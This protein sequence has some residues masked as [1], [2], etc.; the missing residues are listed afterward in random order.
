MVPQYLMISHVTAYMESGLTFNFSSG[1][2]SRM[3]RYVCCSSLEELSSRK[4]GSHEH[5]KRPYMGSVIEELRVKLHWFVPFWITRHVLPV[6]DRKIPSSTDLFYSLFLPCFFFNS[7]FSPFFLPGGELK[8][9]WSSV[10]Y[11]TTVSWQSSGAVLQAPHYLMRNGEGN[12]GPQIIDHVVRYS[13]FDPA[14]F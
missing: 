9:W 6:T 2:T 14:K 1:N 12:E 13:Y 3:H 11:G 10:F 5:P 8:I 4:W 7:T